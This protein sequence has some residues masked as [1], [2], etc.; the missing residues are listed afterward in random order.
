MKMSRDA[1]SIPAAS[2]PVNTHMQ[3]LK[4]TAEQKKICRLR[5]NGIRKVNKLL[6]ENF[7]MKRKEAICIVQSEIR[8]K[9]RNEGFQTMSVN[10]ADN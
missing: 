9:I 4:K 2:T 5:S 8:K 7:R 3:Y 1:G 10:R 6:D